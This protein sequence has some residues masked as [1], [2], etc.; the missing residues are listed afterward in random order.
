MVR[1]QNK[2]R[3]IAIVGAP[4][5]GKSYLARRLAT[6]FNA[7]LFLEGEEGEF[8]SRIEEDIAKNI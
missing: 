2:G 1:S 8:P 3:I 6:Y 4:R 7:E 5:S